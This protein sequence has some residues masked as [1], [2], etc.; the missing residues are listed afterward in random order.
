MN[1]RFHV[2]GLPH[3]QTSEAFNNC[4]FATLTRNFC[5][6]M[7]SLNHH[8]TVYSS[9]ENDAPCDEHVTCIA[10][11]EQAALMGV[12]GPEDILKEPFVHRTYLPESPW[13]PDWNGRVIRE[14]LPRIQDRDFVCIIGGG[15]LF[16]PL[17]AAVRS[18]TIPVE[19]AVGYA[20]VSPNTWHCFG[21]SN[22]QHVVFGLLRYEAWRGRFYDRCIPH[23][24]NP[25]DFEF[26]AEKDDYLLYLGKIKE[27]KGVNVAARAAKETGNRLIVAGQ[28]PTPVEY[29]EVLNRYIDAE[30][31]RELLAGA[32]VV[33]V[34]SLY[35]EPFGM[36]AVEALLSGT[37]IITTPW[38]GLGEINIDGVTGYK[39]NTLQDFIAATNNINKLV[40]QACR[41]RGMR[42]AMDNVRHE[43]NRWFDDLFGLWGEG[44]GKIG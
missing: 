25:S 21:S 32:R 34:P 38:G 5:S 39:C 17:I 7:K 37:P 31:R 13:W 1:Y 4:A 19:Y 30:E 2:V 35:V 33:F 10:K 22:W 44:W 20:G 28:G 15:V 3:T 6:M 8:V 18:R 42:Y 29:G 14:M 40:P 9:E 16:E 43:Y 41:D 36:I 27:D 11:D 12:H 23:Y 24:F 26:R